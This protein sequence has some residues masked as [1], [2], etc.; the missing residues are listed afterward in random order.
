MFPVSF[1]IIGKALTKRITGE[2]Q[3]IALFF[4]FIL[5][6]NTIPIVSYFYNLLNFGFDFSNLRLLGKGSESI[7]FTNY[8]SYFAYNFSLFPLVFYSTRNNSDKIIKRNGITLSIIAIFI[9]GSIGQRTGFFILLICLFIFTI[10][11]GFSFSRVSLSS[12]FFIGFLIFIGLSL[13]N[14]D[15]FNESTI[16]ERLFVLDSDKGILKSRSEIWDIG[17]EEFLNRPDGD[18][19]F[20]G[21]EG[22]Y[23]YAHNFWLDVGLRSG[24]IVLLLLT[25][26]T[27]LYLT[28]LAALLKKTFLLETKMIFLFLSVAIFSTFMVEPIM[29][30]YT[31]FFCSY[32]FVYG[33]LSSARFS[34]IIGK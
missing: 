2:Y 14:F 9:I 25:I 28:N 4:S 33:V 8:A 22:G 23:R 19:H 34:S 13:V 31:L 20:S 10:V 29:E 18:I 21:F 32:A 15:F 6:F 17:L 12:F 30:G 7:S 16:Y 27:V 5:I 24:Y 1:Y 3:I 11:K 26:S